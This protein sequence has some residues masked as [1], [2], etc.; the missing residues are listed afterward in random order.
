MFTTKL[1]QASRR[2][3]DRHR[4]REFENGTRA[5]IHGVIVVVH[6]ADAAHTE[7]CLA[8]VRA[9]LDLL[10]EHTPDRVS[11][12]R[13]RLSSVFVW[14]GLLAAIGTYRH[15]TRMCELDCDYVESDSTT[16]AEVALTLVHEATHARLFSRDSNR[17]MT[18]AQAEWLC[19]SAEVAVARRLPDSE[20][21]VTD[22]KRRL[23]RPPETYSQSAAAARK[24]ADLERRVPYQWMKA[25]VRHFA[26]RRLR[27]T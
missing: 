18:T 20:R 2:W 6:R 8:K 27:S 16:P 26:R 19:I 22:A 1:R 24:L 23:E 21:L 25:I 12:I 14:Y 11:Q 3:T 4:Q 5:S 10:A 9:A 13:E 7:A 15:S 17:R